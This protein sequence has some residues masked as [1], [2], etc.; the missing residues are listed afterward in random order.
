MA[1]TIRP[2]SYLAENN[3]A[4]MILFAVILAIFLAYAYSSLM[5]IST[6][7]PSSVPIN[8]SVLNTN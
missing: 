2:S 6:T 7:V 3:K 5:Q 8:E 4:Y 1:T